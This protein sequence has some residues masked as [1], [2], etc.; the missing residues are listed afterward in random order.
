M[1][2]VWFLLGYRVTFEASA[3][4]SSGPEEGGG[5]PFNPKTTPQTRKNQR[6]K[7]AHDSEW[8]IPLSEPGEAMGE[9][10]GMVDAE[11][12]N[13]GKEDDAADSGAEREME[14]VRDKQY[15]EEL[16]RKTSERRDLEFKAK[17]K[18]KYR[19]AEDCVWDM[20]KDGVEVL[21]E[22]LYN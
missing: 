20:S 8:D 18:C 6:Q 9:D 4:S 3:S 2:P 10:Q 21:L 17:G 19:V 12:S 22:V 1:S 14:Y 13:S 7:D 15:H 11:S 5:L 16:R